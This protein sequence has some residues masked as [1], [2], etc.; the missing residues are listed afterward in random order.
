MAFDFEMRSL[1]KRYNPN[2][3]AKIKKMAAIEAI[4][5]VIM[6]SL[7]DLIQPVRPMHVIKLR[8]PTL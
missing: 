1:S 3:V 6:P 4:I 8:K 5:V 2:G 7:R